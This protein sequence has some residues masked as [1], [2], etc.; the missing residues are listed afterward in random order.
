MK[1]LLTVLLVALTISISCQRNKYV[2]YNA[3]GNEFRVTFYDKPNIKSLQADV[4]KGETA[5]VVLPNDRS[6]QRCE[7][8]LLPE[9]LKEQINEDYVFNVMREYAR[10]Q[11]VSYP[12]MHYEVTDLGKIGTLR[13]YKELEDE[14]GKVWELTFFLKA[15][16]G[17]KSFVMLY[18]SS[19]SENYPTPEIVKFLDS[20]KKV[21]IK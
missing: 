4:L 17:E 18:V 1:I 12:A 16:F 20:I 3:R 10:F 8:G 7:S 6:F 19:P 11:G 14:N 15:V 9:T 13:A 21:N 5:E 2:E